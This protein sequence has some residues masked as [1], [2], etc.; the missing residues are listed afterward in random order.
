MHFDKDNFEKEVLLSSH[1]VIV[2][3]WAPWC[4]PCRMLAPILEE[5]AAEA[6]P[7]VIVGKVNIDEE[8]DLASRYSV[9]SIPTIVLFR[10][11]KEAARLV[12]VQTKE[13]IL[14][15]LED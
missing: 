13:D 6:G 14:H 15:M 2:D 7:N 1:P 8:M 4:A 12:G 11:G 3:F 5:A 10:S 9:M